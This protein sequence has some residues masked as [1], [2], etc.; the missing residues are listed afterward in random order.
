MSIA[1]SVIRLAA[2]YSRNGFGE[3]VRRTKVAAKRAI[4]ANRMI[5]FYCELHKVSPTPVNLPT[6][7]RVERLNNLSELS[8]NDLQDLTSFWNPSQARQNINERFESGASLWL[9]KSEGKLS[10][11]SWTLRARTIAPYYFPMTQDDVQLF[12]FYVFPKFR[13]RAILWFLIMHLLQNLKT[14]GVAR[15][16]GD[17]AE[18]NQASLSFYKMT[19]FQKLGVVRAFTFFGQTYTR[20][21][22]KG[23]DQGA[24]MGTHRRDG[25]PRLQQNLS[26]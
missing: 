24:S 15:V 8:P 20:W 13:G 18:W 21:M 16:F 22:S 7:I 17:V 9:I 12:D 1:S 5:V 14:E 19:P 6:S 23:I 2:Y 11:F 10:G 3:T 26:K 25:K 4:F